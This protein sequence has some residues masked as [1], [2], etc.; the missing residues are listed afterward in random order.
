MNIKIQDH[1]QIK[2]LSRSRCMVVGE[3]GDNDVQ[4]FFHI[5]CQL[6]EHNANLNHPWT[7]F[8]IGVECFLLC[9]LKTCQQLRCVPARSHSRR[10]KAEWGEPAILRESGR[11]AFARRFYCWSN[12]LH[13]TEYLYVM[14]TLAVKSK[15]IKAVLRQVSTVKRVNVSLFMRH[16]K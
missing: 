12:A 7:D 13:V 4:R 6:T 14:M 15:L 10:G 2:N 16:P 11:C 8:V 9:F 1:K 3:G 5:A